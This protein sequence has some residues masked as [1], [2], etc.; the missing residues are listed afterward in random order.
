MKQYPTIEGSAKAPLG[1]PCIAFYKYDG[2]NLRWEWSP[3]RG[4][5]KYGTR[6]QLFNTSDPVFGQAIPLFQDVMGVEIAKR[7]CDLERGLQRII[8]YT[9]F[10]GPNSF[11]GKHEVNDPM[12]LIL[13][14]VELYKRGMMDPRQ[15]V[16]IFGDLPY[17]AQVIYE[18]NLNKQFIDDIRQGNYPVWEGVVAKGDNWMVKIKTKAYFEKLNQVYGT[19]YRK[20]WE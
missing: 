11:A 16:K 19:D 5:Y 15:F 17:S 3:K 10:F 12:Q 2:S 4:W 14:D 7:C 18:G 8:C 13:F 1:E 6:H 20:Y 9:E